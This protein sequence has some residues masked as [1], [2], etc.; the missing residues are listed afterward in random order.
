M[1]HASDSWTGQLVALGCPIGTTVRS[2]PEQRQMPANHCMALECC[3]MEF[4][5]PE[6]QE[7]TLVPLTTKKASLKLGIVRPGRQSVWRN[8]KNPVKWEN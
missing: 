1:H 3:A 4:P 8:T 5:Q 2:V 7:K 6:W